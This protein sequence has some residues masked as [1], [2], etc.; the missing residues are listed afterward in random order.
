MVTYAFINI[1]TGLLSKVSILNY[2]IDFANAFQQVFF[3]IKRL[4]CDR[5]GNQ[6]RDFPL[7]P[8]N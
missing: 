4:L 8:G 5:A 6:H 3:P 2:F 1:E 7:S